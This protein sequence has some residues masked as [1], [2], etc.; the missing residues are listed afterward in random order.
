MGGVRGRGFAHEE[1]AGSIPRPLISL[2]TSAGSAGTKTCDFFSRT[3][4]QR[5][6][7][8]SVVQNCRTSSDA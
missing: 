7:P 1:D 2:P 5:F 6:A 3:L 8:G 4:A